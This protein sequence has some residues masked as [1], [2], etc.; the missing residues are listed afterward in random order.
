MNLFGLLAATGFDA[1]VMNNVVESV[2]TAL[3]VLTDFPCN[4][5]LYGGIAGMG[6]KLFR[7]AKS[8]AK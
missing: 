8:A 5:F 4:I 7:N 2:T 1:S 6:F 3:G